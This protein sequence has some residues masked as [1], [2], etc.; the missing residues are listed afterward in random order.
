MVLACICFDGCTEL[1]V[2]D[3]RSSTA[4]RFRE[5]ICDSIV[6]TFASA[7]GDDFVLMHENTRPHDVVQW[8]MEEA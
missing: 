2:I 5:D 8:Y 3:R 4:M 7:V 6:R 1:Q